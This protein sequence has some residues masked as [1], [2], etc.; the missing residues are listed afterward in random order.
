MVIS[1]RNVLSLHVL[2][3]FTC[4]FVNLI[5]RS[6]YNVQCFRIFLVVGLKILN[7]GFRRRNKFS[8][9]TILGA[10]K[11]PWKPY[12]W[13]FFLQTCNYTWTWTWKE[14]SLLIKVILFFI[15][16]RP[17]LNLW[18]HSMI[19]HHKA[20]DVIKIVSQ[21]SCPIYNFTKFGS[22]TLLSII[23]I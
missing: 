8:L 1:D 15:W 4:K 13:K 22:D 20:Y 2:R 12:K 6:A 18:C 23:Q 17:L 10:P 5:K 14:Q 21:P 7:C 16:K 9:L 19:S 11:C 3:N